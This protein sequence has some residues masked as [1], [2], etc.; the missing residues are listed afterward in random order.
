VKKKRQSNHNA[1]DCLHFF[2]CTADAVGTGS[3]GI[4]DS[5]VSALLSDGLF[6]FIEWA[7]TG[8]GNKRERGER[9]GGGG[10]REEEGVRKRNRRRREE[11]RGREGGGGGEAEE[12][13][14]WWKRRRTKDIQSETI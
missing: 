11:G 12:E 14:R 7:I 2:T 9:E 8:L 10:I 6:L 13:K 4:R 5:S 1:D 3:R